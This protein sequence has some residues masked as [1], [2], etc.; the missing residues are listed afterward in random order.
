MGN[1]KAVSV[2][3]YFSRGGMLSMGGFF[4]MGLLRPFDVVK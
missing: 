2:Y 3:D 1:C 4:V